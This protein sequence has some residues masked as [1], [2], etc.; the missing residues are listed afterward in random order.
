MIFRDGSTCT[1]I[2]PPLY[3]PR[4]VKIS[5]GPPRCSAFSLR[6]V[7]TKMPSGLQTPLDSSVSS[8]PPRP[9]TAGL[10]GLRS[11]PPAPQKAGQFNG[12]PQTRPS[13][14]KTS[15]PS[16]TIIMTKTSS[17]GPEQRISLP[18]APQAC[19]LNFRQSSQTIKGASVKPSAA[20]WLDLPT[21][22]DRTKAAKLSS[23]LPLRGSM[24]VMLRK[25]CCFFLM[26]VF[27]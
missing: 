26:F 20:G 1:G 6:K 15:A 13:T 16:A 9:W 7:P 3:Q 4:A 11:L 24:I 22:K 5:A 18:T 10:F 12:W 14:V 19:T 8:R 27:E 21:G 2:S 23:R 17:T 25:S